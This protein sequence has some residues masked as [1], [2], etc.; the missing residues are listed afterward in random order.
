MYNR[1]KKMITDYIKSGEKTKDNLKLGVE[2]EHF[3]VYKDNY[4]SVS[5]YGED[6]VESTLKNLLDLGWEGTYQGGYLLGLTKNDLSIT[7]EP[8]S[9]LEVSIE[10]K[11]N[12]E[13][14]E[15]SYLNFLD[16]LIPVLENKNQR[17]V[18]LGY[19]PQTKI[20]DIKLLPKKRYDLMFNHF[21][22]RGSHAHNM[23]KGTGAFQVSIDY[24]SEDD[25]VKK[26]RVIN[27]LSPVF[28]GLFENAYFFEGEPCKIHNLRSFIWSNCDSDRAGNIG[29][30]FEDDYSYEKYAEY[31]LERPPIFTIKRGEIVP[32][33]KKLVKDVLDPEITELEELEHLMT[34]FFPD[35]RTKR[36][37]EIRIMDA[38]PYPLNI[39]A[40]ALIKG[41]FY[42]ENN[43]NLVFDFVKDIKYEDIQ[44]IKGEILLNGLNTIIKGKSIIDIG[45][46]LI[47][48]S[49]EALG[50]ESTF[51]KPLEDMLNRGKN[52]YLITKE[53]VEELGIS[54]GLEW[55]TLKR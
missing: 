2:I 33:N 35:A 13:D 52:P 32:T 28:Y 38:V 34:M 4:H 5:Y 36:Y 46:W 53:A 30:A 12:L 18:A 11:V 47:E 17:L 10:A 9:Q 50:E 25:Y 22:S 44:M 37:I 8:G 19:H 1:Q 29:Y 24:L 54:K 55:A 15:R 31:I 7:L 45:K 41:I 6:G 51:L 20:D 48:L 43:L 42:N 23:M 14:I 3:V 16:D 21:K 49:K 39:A 40:V 27:A 26:F